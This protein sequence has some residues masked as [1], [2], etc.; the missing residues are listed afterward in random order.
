M[1]FVIVGGGTAGWMTSLFIQKKMP[2]ADVTVIASSEIGILGAGEGVTPHFVELMEELE[3]VLGMPSVAI[4]WP[5]GSGM[6]FEGVYDRMKNEV[7]LF[8]GDKSTLQLSEDGVNDPVLADHLSEEN[9]TN[10][11]DEID[12]LDADTVFAGHTAAEVEAA[13]E[14]VVTGRD[15]AADLVGVAFVKQ[16]ERVD[17]A[18]AGMKDVRDAQAVFAARGADETHD[19][20]QA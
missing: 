12:L 10:L 3:E 4:T 16:H 7:H 13:L 9:L 1:R 18:V 6:Q 19:V 17:V 14:N 11:R 2:Y 15:G 20:R 8:R 5:I